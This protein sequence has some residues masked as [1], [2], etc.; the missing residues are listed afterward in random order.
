MAVSRMPRAFSSFICQSCRQRL[1]PSTST[2]A[3]STTSVKAADTH[4]QNND[5]ALVGLGHLSNTLNR[6][7]GFNNAASTTANPTSYTSI[8][9]QD[10]ASPESLL[11]EQHSR[12]LD[13]SYTEKPHRLHILATKH[14]THITFVQPPRP[15]IQTASSGISRTS[16]SAADQ[17]KTIDVLLSLSAGNLNFRKAGRGSYDAAY[18]LAA[19][20]L[21]QIKEKGM[22]G[23]VK[24][25]EVV[26]RGFGA[27][28]EAVTKALLGAEGVDVRKRISAVVD[29]TRLKLGG[30]RSKKPRRLG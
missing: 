14:N 17:K 22:L 27:G 13:A 3:F 5:S 25:L 10:A 30:P 18:Q 12:N 23:D 4:S 6:R 19:Y 28:R 16:A 9:D 8:L 7:K 24:K 15:A 29:A 21:K 2:R 26:L 1:L 20:V 11:S